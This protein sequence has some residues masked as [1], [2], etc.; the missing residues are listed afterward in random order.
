MM[1]VAFKLR[2]RVFDLPKFRLDIFNFV[3]RFDVDGGTSVTN[4]FNKDLHYSRGRNKYSEEDVRAKKVTQTTGW[5][6]SRDRVR[7]SI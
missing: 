3:R 2:K 7:V 4:G 5:H 6:L 1:F